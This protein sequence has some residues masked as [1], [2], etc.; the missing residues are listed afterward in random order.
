MIALPVLSPELNTVR[1][2]ATFQLDADGTLK[3][4]VTE[5][6]FGDL[7]ENTRY[8]F[9]HLDEKKQQEYIDRIAGRDFASASITDLKAQNMEALNKD[10]TTSFNVSAT[11]FA[12]SAGPLLMVRPRVLGSLAPPVDHKKRKVSVDLEH[13]MQASDSFDIEIPAGY[14]VDELPDPVKVDMG[15]ASYE[16]STVVQGKMLHYTRTYTV[17][18]VSL[19][20]EEY[21]ELVKLAGVIDNDEQSRAVLKRGP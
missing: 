18:K 4:S 5:K 10:M 21:P 14:V 15:F 13:T 17:R 8:F 11:H 6:R 9:T 3:G 2:S 7:A 19:P 20:A 1:R 12:T 16:S